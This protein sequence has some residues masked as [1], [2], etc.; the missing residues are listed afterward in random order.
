MHKAN[1]LNSDNSYAATPGMIPL[2]SCLL[3]P[4]SHQGLCTSS[5]T[6]SP[7][8][9]HLSQAHRNAEKAG[10]HISAGALSWDAKAVQCFKPMQQTPTLCKMCMAAGDG[11]KNQEVGSEQ[12][13]H[14]SLPPPA[15]AKCWETPLSARHAVLCSA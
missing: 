13:Q 2:F 10:Q 3:A 15:A 12:L 4:P 14:L 1:K 8:F 5:Y 11:W 7:L 6:V 9:S